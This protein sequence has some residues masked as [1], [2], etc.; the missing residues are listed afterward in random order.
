MKAWRVHQY[1]E[2]SDVLHLDEVDAPEPGAGE[3]RIRVEAVTLNFN[4]LDGIHGRYA[5]VRVEPP[6]IP[7][8]EVLGRVETAARAPRRGSAS[9][10]WRSRR[11][12]TAATR[13]SSSRRPR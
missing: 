2:P 6:Y 12:P 7:G 13:R 1:G 11:V 4:D 8:M 5:T 9:A 10:S 3:V